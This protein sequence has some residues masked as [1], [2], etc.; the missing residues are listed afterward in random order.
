MKLLISKFTMYGKRF[1]SVDP[2]KIVHSAKTLILCQETIT[3][4]AS[5][6]WCELGLRRREIRMTN[7]ASYLALMHCR[8]RKRHMRK[9]SLPP[10]ENLSRN[11]K[12]KDSNHVFFF[13]DRRTPKLL[14]ITIFWFI[15]KYLKR[16]TLSERITLIRTSNNFLPQW[17]KNI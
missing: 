15:M 2:N 11:T 7:N 9:R 3:I 1:V 5:T 6:C 4:G 13:R 12:I 8:G 17:I 16:H 14:N 10:F